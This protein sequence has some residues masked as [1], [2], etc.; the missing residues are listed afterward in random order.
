MPFP[1]QVAKI[2]IADLRKKMVF[3]TGPRQVGKTWLARHLGVDPNHFVYLNYDQTK[4]REIMFQQ[5]WLPSTQLLVL[6]EIHKF[7]DWKNWVKGVYDTRP[8]GL[9][10]LVTGSARLEIFREA[11]DSLAGR[12]F[13]HRLLP[14]TISELKHCGEKISIDRLLERGGFPEPYFAESDIDANRWRQ[15][16]LDSLIRTDIL[17]F[18]Q[19]HDFRAIHL[20]F[21]LLQDRV[22]SPISFNSIAE[23]VGI[24][25]NTVKKYVEILEALYIVFRVTPYSK[26]IARSLLKE[27]KIY[28]FDHGLVKNDTGVQFENLVANALLKHCYALQDQFGR[29]VHL[30]YLRTKE[31][32]EVDFCL[33]ENELPIQMYEAKVSD[34][35]LS[36]HLLYFHQRY[37]IPGMQ[38]LKH[39]RQERMDQGLQIRDA[40]KVLQ[41]LH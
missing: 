25:P 16:Y 22:G 40:V 35:Q 7:P 26:N 29:E 20:V 2:L 11:G 36:P 27:P 39:C 30:H 4:D 13:R 31:K 5:A 38:L 17:D 24:S 9:Q 3:L 32:R 21:R 33:V 28:F 18:E 23:D 41:D 34:T 15:Q 1:R 37:G 12:F 10:I 14:I 6:D 19:I 8:E